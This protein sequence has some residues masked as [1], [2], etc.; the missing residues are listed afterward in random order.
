MKAAYLERDGENAVIVIG[1]LPTPEPGPGEVRVRI[2]YAA[3]NH[4]DN[5]VRKG[6][7]GVKLQFP[8]I[9]AGDGLG[10]VERMGAGVTGVKIGDE[11]IV[12]PGLSCGKCEACTQGWES[13]CPSYQILGEH[14]SGT[15]AE[16]VVVPEANCFIKPR[17][18]E[19][20]QAAGMALAYATAWQMVVERAGVKSGQ[21]VLV[22]AA[23][24]GVGSAAIQIAKLLG[25][26]VYATASSP[27]KQSLAKSLGADIAL[28]YEDFLA[29]TKQL[30]GKRGVDVIID[31]V[32]EKLWEANLKALR[33]GGVLVTCGSSSG[34]QGKT[35]L[36]HLFYRQLSLLGSTMGSK[37]HFPLILKHFGTGKLKTVIDRVY[38]FAQANDAIARLENQEVLGKV[39]IQVD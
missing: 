10:K 17:G 30:T 35:D 28:G 11:V 31:H 1:E 26:T 36:R 32:G 4:L 21:S 9:L 18:V 7:A 20:K 29:E 25:A 27:A 8:H 34:Y 16:F 3:L 13:L 22:H 2:K 23:A 37:R 39:L 33:W 15:L 38:P 24:S 6:Q 19:D 12:H 5:W 14:R